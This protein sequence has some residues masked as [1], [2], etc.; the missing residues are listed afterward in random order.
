MC[1][2]WEETEQIFFVHLLVL[3]HLV[4]VVALAFRVGIGVGRMFR[5]LAAVAAVRSAPRGLPCERPGLGLA[6][7]LR[8]TLL[9]RNLGRDRKQMRFLGLWGIESPT[10]GKSGGCDISEETEKSEFFGASLDFLELNLRHMAK[11]KMGVRHLGRERKSKC[12]CL[13]FFN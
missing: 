9:L 4:L 3:L 8:L 6:R 12:F 11:V 1:D 13:A 7:P 2:I 5:E 10:C